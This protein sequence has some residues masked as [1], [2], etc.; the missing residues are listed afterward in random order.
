MKYNS[1]SV[2]SNSF[3][4][5][6]LKFHFTVSAGL[7]YLQIFL[8]VLAKVSNFSK[9]RVFKSKKSKEVIGID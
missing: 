7:Q 4:C 9:V 3:C 2:L 1:A 5:L 6:L 8:G